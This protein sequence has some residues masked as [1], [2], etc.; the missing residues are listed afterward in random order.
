MVVLMRILLAIVLLLVAATPYAQ[1]QVIDVSA[2]RFTFTPSEIK[3]TVGTPLEI[4]LKSE[5]TDH[6]F[7]IAGT[8]INVSIPKRGR[9][10]TTVTFTP[11]KAGRYAFE[12]S[13]VCGA[14]HSFMR[15]VIVVRER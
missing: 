8:D 7:K 15:G 9:G 6:G 13:H 2:E 11:E 10:T 3:T 1:T 5:D 12:C 14:G 4:R